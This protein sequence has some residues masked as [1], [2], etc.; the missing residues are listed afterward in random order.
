MS[1]GDFGVVPRHLENNFNPSFVDGV[2]LYASTHPIEVMFLFGMS[3]LGRYR[4]AD[5][6]ETGKLTQRRK[7]RLFSFWTI[8]LL[9]GDRVLGIARSSKCHLGHDSFNTKSII[10]YRVILW[11]TSLP[12]DSHAALGI[13]HQVFRRA[14]ALHLHLKE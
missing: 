4:L 8:K 14:Q 10:T 3:Y 11:L 7:I 5:A 9:D 2:G 1:N 6:W 13:W 12:L